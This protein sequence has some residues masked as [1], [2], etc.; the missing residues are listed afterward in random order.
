MG[1]S[2][3]MGNAVSARQ[4]SW[5]RATEKRI[6]FTTSILGSIRNVKVLGLTEVMSSMIE[7][8]RTE[9][10]KFLKSSASSSQSVYAWVRALILITTQLYYVTRLTNELTPTFSQFSYN[11]WTTCDSRC[12]CDISIATGL[13][14]SC[15][16]RSHHVIV[17]YKLDDY[18]AELPFDGNSRHI[19]IS[20]LPE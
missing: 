3:A 8:L 6:N 11:C 20:R 14:R 9:E 5:L 16:Q 2:F 19:C 13:G 1:S 4:E 10:L 18:S 7:G 17:A 15:R 12:L